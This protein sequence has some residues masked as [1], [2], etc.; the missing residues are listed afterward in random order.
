MLIQEILQHATLDNK[1]SIWGCVLNKL[2]EIVLLSTIQF[3]KFYN[4]FDSIIWRKKLIN[5]N[6][7]MEIAMVFGF[8][9]FKQVQKSIFS[10]FPV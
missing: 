6:D 2:T 9:N 4:L 3:F 8:L 7:A 1:L 5:W 10:Y